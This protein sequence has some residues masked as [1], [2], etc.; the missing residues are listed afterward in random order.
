[1]KERKKYIFQSER[2]RKKKV[3]ERFERPYG[4]T[5]LPYLHS[6]ILRPIN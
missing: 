2:E 4:R 3:S 1:M 5:S 6:V